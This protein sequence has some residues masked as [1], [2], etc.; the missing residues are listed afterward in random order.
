MA[1]AR[2]FRVALTGPRY[3]IA[4]IVLCVVLAGACANLP[5]T[6]PATAI[7]DGK[8]VDLGVD[9]EVAVYFVE[10]Y[11][12][13][14][15][16]RPDLDAKIDALYRE[17]D[18]HALPDRD[19][20]KRIADAF[21]VDFA[22]IYLADRIARIPAN[23]ILRRTYERHLA[24]AAAAHASG[25]DFHIS[26]Q[27]FEYEVVFVPGYHYE[28]YPETGADL[29]DPRGALRD[30]GLETRWIAT[31]EKGSIDANAELIAAYL[32]RLARAQ[33]EIIVISASKSGPEVALAL[34]QLS[35]AD[36]R[37]V[38]AWIN[39]VG[40]LQG[41]PLADEVLGDGL[42]SGYRDE[43]NDAGLQSL[44][45]G[46]SRARYAQ[47]KAREN[48][49]T[50]NYIAIPVTGTVSDRARR[51]YAILR[52]YGPNDGLNLLGDV[53]APNS[54]TLMEFGHDHYLVD[55]TI[56]PRTIALVNTT[57]QWLENCQRAE[58]V[59]W[60]SITGAARCDAQ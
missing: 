55:E 16:A 38:K 6:H 23:R 15:R 29:A 34:S 5:K 43:L 14:R 28:T 57:I 32:R 60:S 25:A 37:R 53:F 56:R 27:T 35:P 24:R 58:G 36:A 1:F 45:T 59:A 17:H 33:R 26:P 18:D 50:V 11:L 10:S 8:P 44:T 31:D 41:T 7:V 12:A 2:P 22:A 19:Q 54:V 46:R 47:V 13:G 40:T 4:P 52:P 39:I 21:S 3:A 20:L 30:A 48:L 51:T 42:L 49:L 9:S